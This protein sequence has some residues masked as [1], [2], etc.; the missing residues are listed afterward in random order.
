M[1]LTPRTVAF[2]VGAV[3]FVLL[4]PAT[5][6]AGC[7]SGGGCSSSFETFWGLPLPPGV[8]SAAPASVVA[9]VA[10]CLTLRRLRKGEG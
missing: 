10:G 1:A 5:G 4:F 7:G 2:I 3:V 6:V 8:W 9:L